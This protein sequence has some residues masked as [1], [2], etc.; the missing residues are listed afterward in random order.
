MSDYSKNTREELVTLCKEAKIKGYSTKKKA[1][2]IELLNNVSKSTTIQFT[3]VKPFLKWVG[4]KTQ[5]LDKVLELFPKN[6]TNYHEPFLGGG[7]VLLGILSHIKDNKI[8]VSGNIYAS[9]IN[10]NIINLY[11]NIQMTPEDFIKEITILIKEYSECNGSEINRTPKNKEEAMKSQESYYY[12]IRSQFNAL[13]DKTTTSASAM[14]VFMNKTCFRGVYREGPKGFNVPFGNYKNPGIIDEEHIR[15]VSDMFKNVIFTAQSFQD[16]LI[17]VKKDDF[18][19]LDPP[20]APE[21]DTS[22]VGY[23]ADGFGLDEHNKLFEMTKNMT[24][25]GVKWAMS[26]ASVKLV[27]DEFKEPE[28]KTKI[29]SARRSINS[30]NPEA[31][32]DEVLIINW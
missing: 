25:T 8:K 11:K 2:L 27:K 31:K 6:I 21:S 4:G 29:I 17:K 30:K 18:V 7:S 23:T 26:N 5:I 12:W 1:E 15:Q 20:Y 19:Y 9:D 13:T 14:L 16:S 24:T 3:V 10:S 22:F 32:T 28:Y